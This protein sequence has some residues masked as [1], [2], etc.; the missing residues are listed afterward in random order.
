[1]SERPISSHCKIFINKLEE[2]ISLK[3]IHVNNLGV[4]EG[5][6]IDITHPASVEGTS[7][8]I[9]E[10][11]R[12][13]GEI[14]IPHC[15]NESGITDNLYLLTV[16]MELCGGQREKGIKGCEIDQVH[17]HSWSKPSE[18]VIGSTHV[19]FDCED[20]DKHPSHKHCIEKLADAIIKLDRYT[21]K[22]CG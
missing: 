3:R 20:L 5:C 6:V 7:I 13:F 10:R 9:D 8:K 21:S 15:K 16:G 14:M 11:G 17:V 22:L 1:M 2:G 19:H 18:R 4:N 12:P